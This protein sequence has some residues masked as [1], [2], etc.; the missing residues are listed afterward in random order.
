LESPFAIRPF[1][2]HEWPTYRAMRLRS[3]ADSPGAFG[4]NL[5]EEELRA[6][7]DWAARLSAAC[8]S[9]KDHPLMA[10]CGGAPAG[11]V[12]AKV[13]G[14]DPAVI[15]IFQMWVAPES[16][17]HGVAAALLRAAIAW[18]RSR[19]AGAVH[20]DVFCANSS[21]VRLYLREGFENAGPPRPRHPGSSSLEQSMRLVLG[22]PRP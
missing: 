12:W 13:D 8:V 10:E 5:A 1:A 16:R 19:N 7:E 4:S 3:L 21:A 17:G 14:A 18:A 22:Q 11:L 15:N 9:G 2:P 20:L 6:P